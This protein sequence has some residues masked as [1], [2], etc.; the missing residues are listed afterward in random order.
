ML[1]HVNC[2]H[3]KPNDH[4]ACSKTSGQGKPRNATFRNDHQM[5]L[6][7]YQSTVGW[8]ANCMENT[9]TK[10]ESFES[11]ESKSCGRVSLCRSV[12]VLLNFITI[13]IDLQGLN[14]STRLLI[15]SL[16]FWK[17]SWKLWRGGSRRS[18]Y[19]LY[20]HLWTRTLH[21]LKYRLVIFNQFNRINF[22]C[23]TGR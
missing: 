4:N 3:G 6:V 17:R 21:L 19:F 11:V 22:F 16:W 18:R 10:F 8:I 13:Y 20:A 5:P 14:K 9:R 12:L 2:S 1:V 7:Q 15:M 23:F